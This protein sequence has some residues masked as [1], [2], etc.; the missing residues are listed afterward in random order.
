M[1][2]ESQDPFDR[3]AWSGTTYAAPAEPFKVQS[4]SSI[5]KFLREGV[6]PPSIVYMGV[7][8]LIQVS[9]MAA[10]LAFQYFVNG[11]WLRAADGAIV[12]FA[13]TFPNNVTR[14]FTTASF[15]LGEGFLLSINV[16]SP[17]AVTN[18][19]EQYAVVSMIRGPA[20]VNAG[21]QTLAAG[22]CGG[23]RGLTWPGGQYSRPHEGPGVLR[24]IVGTTPAAG[25]EIVETVPT[26][27][28]WR[29]LAFRFG[30]TTSAAVANRIPQLV[31]DDGVNV[32]NSD[33]PNLTQTAGLF[34]TYQ[35]ANSPVPVQFALNGFV[36][37]W[38]MSDQL[39]LTANHRIR[40]STAALQGGDQYSAPTYMVIEWLNT[41]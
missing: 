6:Q 34:E 7:G 21:F 30:L 38:P 19:S 26:S 14:G 24:V 27:A 1:A 8:D 12:P 3:R 13:Q 25:A 17:N 11:R 5:I 2:K 28:R 23:L 37:F 35:F 22:Y 39:I 9:V 16:T 20:G 15:A 36:N 32:Y 4:Q 41:E 31:R 10:S 18:E 33:F 40:T 29:L